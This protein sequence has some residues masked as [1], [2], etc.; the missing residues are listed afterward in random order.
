MIVAGGNGEITVYDA[1]TLEI[2]SQEVSAHSSRVN[3]V[4]FSPDSLKIAS[5]G[6]DASTRAQGRYDAG[7][8]L[9]VFFCR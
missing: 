5:G 1:D 8:A 6:N 7:D 4:A 9:T 2:L 3:D